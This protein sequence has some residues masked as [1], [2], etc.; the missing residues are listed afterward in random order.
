[1]SSMKVPISPTV[2]NPRLRIF[3]A[4]FSSLSTTQP[5][6]QTWVLVDSVFLTI[7]PQLEQ[8]ELVYCGFTATV[9]LSN[10]LPKYSIQIR[11]W[12]Q[13]A[14]LIDLAKQW[15]YAIFLIIMLYISAQNWLILQ[16]RFTIKA[17]VK[18]RG[19]KP[20]FLITFVISIAWEHN[21]LVYDFSGLV[22]PWFNFTL[23]PPNRWIY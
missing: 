13:D 20:I 12:Y 23:L 3:L 21:F 4:A 18:R 10:T 5:H 11:N 8:Y 16:Q 14:S 1:M 22:F 17:V 15:F 2:L 7:S 6:L 9:T 19:F